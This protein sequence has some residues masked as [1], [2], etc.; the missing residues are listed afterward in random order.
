MQARRETCTIAES[1]ALRDALLKVQG[2]LR[3]EL[4]HQKWLRSGTGCNLDLDLQYVWNS[5]SEHC[6]CYTHTKTPEAVCCFVSSTT[7]PCL[8]ASSTHACKPM[9]WSDN[10]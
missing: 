5:I 4:Q 9:D 8:S 1:I 10:I 3:K 2:V 7:M 6:N